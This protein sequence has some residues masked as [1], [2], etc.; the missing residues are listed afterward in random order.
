MHIII[1]SVYWRSGW[2]E[3]RAVSVDDVNSSAGNQTG[4]KEDEG[5]M[6][7]YADICKCMSIYSKREFEARVQRL[8]KEINELQEQK[9]KLDYKSQMNTKQL[10]TRYLLN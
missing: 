10:V 7:I 5:I 2:R 8:Q 1:I 4:G 6:L 3:C 9:T